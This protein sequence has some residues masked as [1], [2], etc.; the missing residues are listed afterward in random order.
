MHFPEILLILLL[1]ALGLDIL[2]NLRLGRTLRKQSPA[3]QD[4][5]V[6]LFGVFS[7]TLTW[8]RHKRS[9][10]ASRANAIEPG[11]G[12]FKKTWRGLWQGYKDWM[13]SLWEGLRQAPA[14]WKAGR[15]AHF[16]AAVRN[17]SL[18]PETPL[19]YPEESHLQVTV[20]A[21]PEG[22]SP[23]SVAWQRWLWSGVDLAQ[24]TLITITL[25][26]YLFFL[27]LGVYLFTRLYALDR[28]PIYFFG[29][30]ASIT[31]YA[32]RLINSGFKDAF[33]P[34]PVYVEAA[35][36]RWT[37]LL[38]MYFQALSLS[39][40]GKSIFVTRAT[41]ALISILAVI[42]VAL[43]LKW[44]FKAKSWWAGALLLGAIPAW[45]LHSRTAFETVMTTAFYGCFLL[46]YLLYRTKSPRYIFPAVLFAGATFYTYSN[47]QVIIVAAVVLLAISDLGYHLR[48]WR[49]LVLAALFAVVLA[50]PLLNFRQHEP[51]AMGEHL[52]AINSY[53]TGGI[54]LQEKLAIFAG[55]Y[56]YALSPQ[57]WFVSNA[58]DLPRHRMAGMGHLPFFALPLIAGGVLLCLLKVRSAPYRAV[59]LAGLAAPAG[60]AL[61]EVGITRML[62]FVVPAA[63]VAGLGLDWL[64]ERLR[65]KIR[66]RYLAIPVF[67]ALVW[68][69]FNLLRV[70][71][72]DGPL[73]FKDYGLYGMQ[74]GAK[75]LFVDTIPAI[76]EKDPQAR[77]LVSSAWANG[78]DN[79]IRFFLSPAERNRVGMGGVS[80]YLFQR[81]PL[82]HNMVFIMTPAEFEKAITSGKFE[83]PQIDHILAY[84]DGSP[85]FYVTRLGYA[86]GADALFTAEK[87]ERQ[88]LV[89]ADVNLDGQMVHLR[90]SH[91]DMGVPEYMFD[92][93]HFTLMRGLEA[94]PFILEM[95]FSQPRSLTGIQADFGLMDIELKATLYPAGGGSPVTY[96]LTHANDG[97]HPELELSFENPPA[98]VSEIHF[99]IRNFSAGASANIHIMELK[100][101]P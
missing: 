92:G 13:K 54:S 18:Q 8:L 96:T 7:P 76:L 66:Y 75:Q 32:E 22:I 68:L 44:V 59:L 88:K 41:S 80:A 45:L 1:V 5:G 55:K 19:P 90:Y 37:P 23:R 10:A 43:I 60:A 30:E 79:F 65:G 67:L 85:G 99:G 48:N 81:L 42:S 6:Y 57:Y 27:S 17:G 38:P 72:V 29:D 36:H 98:Q 82:D 14:R 64:L 46:C 97:Q 33:G 71:L 63:I 93:D 12:Q 74:Y 16:T 70:A 84:P 86:P 78:T 50:Y 39:L 3:S 73:W 95:E 94:N 101:L 61:A 35:S 11:G 100:L 34:L 21:L 56:T 51:Q 49:S 4:Q 52:R 26:G 9:G 15:P 24:A 83:A 87:A 69:N 91:T 28:F 89:E 20:E 2:L 47:A 31:L 40:F 53:W 77:I 58:T 62:A 25:E